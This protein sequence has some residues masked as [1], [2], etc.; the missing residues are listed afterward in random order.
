MSSSRMGNQM[1]P[2]RG[3]RS[4]PFR[5]PIKRQRPSYSCTECT[6][7]KLRCSKQIPCLACIE[8]GTAQ[9]CRRRDDL[10]SRRGSRRTRS[11]G[12][13]GLDPPATLTGY[14]SLADSAE[15]ANTPLSYNID[16][17][18]NC[19]PG[20]SAKV[21]VSSGKPTEAPGLRQ[22]P[23]I[24]DSV[25][26]DAAVMLEFL[27]LSRQQVLHLAQID[28][29]SQNGDRCLP[30]ATD[31]VFTATQ[32]D[33]MM[34]YHQECIAWI[35]NIVHMPTFREQ[36]SLSLNSVDAIEGAWL[37]LYYAML[38]VTLYHTHPEKLEEFEIYS[39]TELSLLCYQKS[40]DS[41]NTADFMKNH[42]IFS[43][44][45]ICLLIYIGH[46]AGQSDRIS[47]LL[48]SASRIA[49]CLGLHR[50]G[51]DTPAATQKS[52]E[53]SD[54]TQQLVD[55]EVSKRVW[56]FLV[57]QDWLQIPYNNTYNIHPS[58]FNTP[59]PT[60]C[61]EEVLEMATEDHIMEKSQET[62]T[63]GSYTSVLNKG[64]TKSPNLG[65]QRLTTSVSVIIWKMQDRTCQKLHPENSDKMGN[66]YSEVL[67][68]DRELKQL[69]DKMPRFFKP[70]NEV[71]SELP[72]Y[73]TQI[74]SVLS[75]S[76]AHKFYSVHRHFQIPSLKDPRFA[77][78]KVSCLPLMRRYLLNFLF[79]PDN[80]FTHIVNNLWTVN[81]QVLT[82]AVWLLFELIFTKE[83]SQIFEAQEIRDLAVR[84]LQFLQRNQERSTI[85]KRGV[86]LIES[87]LDMDMAIKTGTREQFSLK[88]IISRVEVKDSHPVSHGES[89][90]EPNFSQIADLFLGDYMQWED[91]I[92]SFGEI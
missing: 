82:A 83:N 84:S 60:H 59:M 40:I 90:P 56:W 51:P 13:E 77:Y 5:T 18:A 39:G 58:Q 66:L 64:T 1:N 69:I 25:S 57:R 4:R 88:E 62:Y 55:R 3:A 70:G 73:I 22:S 6:R 85:A 12:V 17:T 29:P 37:S 87:L 32:V 92:N 38:A 33:N 15:P 65:W 9:D 72:T 8:R 42:S 43:V 35:H 41:L 48:A 7:R 75:L 30:D 27:A 14:E 19:S 61:E 24:L 91:I 78:T 50:L 31:M 34:T 81:T 52:T 76:Y 28:Q 20:M 53:S 16:A 86:G 89:S 68:A 71:V 36:C 11:R 46:N 44:Q 67:Q 63:Q 49:Q 80:P 21:E 23:K 10:E 2:T 26:Q 79:L 45:A 74:S 47:V 54:R